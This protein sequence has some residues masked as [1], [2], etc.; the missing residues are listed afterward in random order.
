MP[1]VWWSTALISD[2][3]TEELLN[4]LILSKEKYKD[5]FT[6]QMWSH[7]SCADMTRLP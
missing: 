4:I 6:H 1:F 2:V 3:T 7:H 5:G